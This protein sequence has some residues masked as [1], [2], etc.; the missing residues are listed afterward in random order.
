MANNL[1]I[2]VPETSWPRSPSSPL[3]Y[4]LWLTTLK[5]FHNLIPLLNGCGCCLRSIHWTT[6]PWDP[7]IHVSFDS[8]FQV[9]SANID[10]TFDA[11]YFLFQILEG[12]RISQIIT[13][14]RRLE[15]WY[16]HLRAETKVGK[17]ISSWG[18]T[19]GHLT[20]SM[21]S[22]G[23][24]APDTGHDLMQIFDARC[25]PVG[26]QTPDCVTNLCQTDDVLSNGWVLVSCWGK[27]VLM[28][29]WWSWPMSPP[30]YQMTIC[31]WMVSEVHRFRWM[32][33]AFSDRASASAGRV[34]HT[35]SV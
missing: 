14:D 22:Y 7:I 21:Y 19:S 10:G 24:Q 31:R 34:I 28:C 20:I 17:R 23:G 25:Q 8:C 26:S 11:S 35:K 16:S 32:T 4:Q 27:S 18:Y 2:D 33:Q 6:F 12:L 9:W 1:L 13:S 29:S 3:S 15:K 5:D 30:S